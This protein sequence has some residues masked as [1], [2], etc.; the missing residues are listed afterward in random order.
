MSQDINDSNG[1]RLLHRGLSFVRKGSGKKIATHEDIEEIVQR[2]VERRREDILDNVGEIVSLGPEAIEHLGTQAAE[3]GLAVT[4]S[5]NADIEVHERLTR[6]PAS[7][8]DE[9]LNGDIANWVN[10]DDL[11]SK[12]AVWKY[13]ASH[14]I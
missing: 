2:R 9:E 12:K 5:D 6:E 10:R 11:L 3:N 8:L 1:N 13:Y 4:S 7:T 14:T